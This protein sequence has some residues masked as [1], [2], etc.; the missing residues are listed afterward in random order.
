MNEQRL[1]A[2]EYFFK[3]YNYTSISAT[4]GYRI[5]GIA[6]RPFNEEFLDR[7]SFV[8]AVKMLYIKK[9]CILIGFRK[10]SEIV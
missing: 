10:L 7:M 4:N 3:Y 9:D 1:D 2:A 6:D 8:E 5:Y